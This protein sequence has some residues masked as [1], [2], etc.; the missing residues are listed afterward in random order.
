MFDRG[1]FQ[2]SGVCRINKYL[3]GRHVSETRNQK[4]TSK[5]YFFSI[6]LL[7]DAFRNKTVDD[8]KTEQF[9]SD[10]GIPYSKIHNTR[11]VKFDQM[12]VKS[13]RTLTWS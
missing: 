1:Y 12:N 11:L 6:S 4:T 13:Q 3:H 2:K 9:S 5:A 7:L 10:Y 8:V